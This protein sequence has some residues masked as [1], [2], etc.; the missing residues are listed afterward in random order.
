MVLLNSWLNM[1]VSKYSITS[2][3]SPQS[4]YSAKLLRGGSAG[5]MGRGKEIDCLFTV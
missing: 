5:P 3:A 2:S 4:E 1:G